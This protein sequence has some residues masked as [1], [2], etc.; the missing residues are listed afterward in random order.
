MDF[1]V[2]RSEYDYPIPVIVQVDRS[3]FQRDQKL[4]P[5]RGVETDNS[6]SLVY[7]Y[8]SRLAAS[9]IRQLLKSKLV[10]YITLD[11]PIRPFGDTS[12]FTDPNFVQMDIVRQIV[13]ADQVDAKTPT[14]S[15]TAPTSSA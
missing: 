4:R 7:G 10:Q 5:A 3:F 13:G 14:S 11:A 2:L 8:R 15:V 12:S 1:L 6:L 9:H